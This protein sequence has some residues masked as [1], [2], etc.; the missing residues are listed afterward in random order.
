MP[1]IH[2]RKHSKPGKHEFTNMK[3]D[4]NL[5]KQEIQEIFF[6]NELDEVC[7]QHGMAYGDFTSLTRR[8]ASDKIFC[9]KASSIAKNPKY[10]RYQSGLAFMVYISFWWKNIRPCCR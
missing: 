9:H 8:A 5:K 1:E 2:S 4:K 7:I 10:D 3:E 6:Q